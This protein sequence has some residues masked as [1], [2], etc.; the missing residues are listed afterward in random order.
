[1]DDKENIFAIRLPISMRQKLT[2]TIVAV[3]KRIIKPCVPDDGGHA[4][5]IQSVI[6][7]AKRSVMVFTSSSSVNVLIA[8][9][10]LHIA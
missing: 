5:R 2:V 4:C 8:S 3:E 10:I 9:A 7:R 6:W 1:M